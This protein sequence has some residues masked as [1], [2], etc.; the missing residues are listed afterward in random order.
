ML[1]V[2]YLFFLLSPM[3]LCANKSGAGA[4]TQ[5]V[6]GPITPVQAGPLNSPSQ[7]GS[8]PPPPPAPQT[9]APVTTSAPLP[10]P[11]VIA[12]PTPTPTPPAPSA[13]PG[14]PTSIDTPAPTP[15]VPTPT[16]TPTPSPTDSSSTSSATPTAIPTP[17]TETVKESKKIKEESIT[18]TSIYIKNKDK[19]DCLLQEVELEI[20]DKEDK[21]RPF[22]KKN[23]KIA[24]PGME[25]IYNKGSIVGF[26]ITT[27][28]TSV[29]AFNKIIS[30]T[31]SGT[32]I[33]L[34][35]S[36]NGLSVNTPI[37]ITHKDKVWGITK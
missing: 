5:V 1:Y 28:D 3:Q 8:N 35:D 2:L 36:S 4:P 20:T 10:V 27:K 34:G 32:K 15:P 16:P 33:D 37:V 9:A 29:K 7:T 21:S 19:K 6:A 11:T 25:N 17:P 14:A 13:A 31:V 30:I 26:D 22:I 24:L 18:L 23:L 12:T